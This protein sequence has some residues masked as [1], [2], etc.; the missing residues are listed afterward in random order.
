MTTSARLQLLPLLVRHFI[1]TVHR[2]NIVRPH[3]PPVGTLFR[4]PKSHSF[5][6]CVRGLTLLPGPVGVGCPGRNK[7]KGLNCAHIR[8]GE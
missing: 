1:D 3:V 2:P 8:A 4:E 6:E 7:G 5:S